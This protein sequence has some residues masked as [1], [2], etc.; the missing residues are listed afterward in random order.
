MKN[1]TQIPLKR[2]L[3]LSLLTSILSANIVS[4]HQWCHDGT[5]VQIADVSWNESSII[6][7]YPGLIPDDIPIWVVGN[8]NM[9]I[10]YEAVRNYADAFEGGGGGF[11]GYSV[12]NS[13]EVKEVAYWPHNYITAPALY[14]ISQGVKFR[15]KKCYTIAP[16]TAV[17]DLEFIALP[18]GTIPG[19]TSNDFI[20][21]LQVKPLGGL[22]RLEDY[23]NN[24]NNNR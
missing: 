12:A 14:H 4:A 24:S 20:D 18:G 5:I 13:G 21:R 7:N 6:T 15:L 23:W 3:H 2:I 16:M 19:E 11:G 22:E 9:H 8:V 10:T 17:E 1:I